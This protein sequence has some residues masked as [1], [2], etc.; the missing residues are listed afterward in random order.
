MQTHDPS[1]AWI[2]HAMQ[3]TPTLID[4]PELATL[5]S[6]TV[7]AF[8]ERRE[9]RDALAF[10]RDLL[11][12][13]DP[14]EG[15]NAPLLLD[16]YCQLGLLCLRAD[17]YGDAIR[18]FQQAAQYFKRTYP[19]PLENGALEGRLLTNTG[20]AFSGQKQFD[21]ALAYWRLG[22]WRL[23]NAEERAV[24]H[25]CI[26][27]VRRMCQEQAG[28]VQ[29]EALWQASETWYHRLFLHSFARLMSPEEQQ[30]FLGPS[31]R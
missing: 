30:R 1:S 3:I 14:A 27:R 19:G 5:R 2:A 23:R 26:E 29:F 24:P 9:P 21:L 11:E 18:Y 28:E 4:H 13:T 7:A 22:E 20:I 10:G 8:T 12:R 16:I 15:G 17:N 6:E 25:E 31:S